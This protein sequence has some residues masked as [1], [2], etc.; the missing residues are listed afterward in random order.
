[1]TLNFDLEKSRVTEK[2]WGREF[3]WTP[4]WGNPPYAGKLLFINPGQR[5]SLQRHR[6][7]TE[8]ILVL[9]GKLILNFGSTTTE[10]L[11]GEWAHIPAG[12]VH[13]FG[14]TKE[15]GCVLVEVST[16]HMDDI[17]RIEDDYGR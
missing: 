8:S 1:M 6:K 7:K 13:R 12:S 3:L 4:T 14:A 5:L 10:L 16:P 17:V 15:A 2:P 9:D 11:P